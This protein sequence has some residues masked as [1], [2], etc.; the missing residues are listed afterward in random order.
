MKIT[1][2]QI[3]PFLKKPDGQVRAILLYGPDAGLARER[4]DRLARLVVPDAKD[5][6]RIADFSASMLKDHPG[7]LAEEAAQLSLMGGRRV[8]MVREASDRFADAFAAFLEEPVGEA[9]ILVE[10]GDL[11]GRSRL[12]QLFEGG[13][14]AAAIGC[15]PDDRATVASLVEQ[16]L[17][18]RGLAIEGDA[19]DYLADNLGADRGVTRSE[20]EKLAL[21]KGK[22]PGRITLDEAQMMVG[23]SAAESLDAVALAAA[24]GNQAALEIALTRVERAKEEPTTILRAATRHLLRL[25]ALR[26]EVDG[27][28]SPDAAIATAR[29][30]VHFSIKRRIAAQLDRWPS[31]RT[32]MALQRLA[33]AEIDAK[34]TGLPAMTI[35]KRALMALAS[36][37]RSPR[38]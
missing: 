36:Q 28:K 17:A 33:E 35:C 23:D 19:L 21:F 4:L 25:Q 22:G 6:F 3:E 14:N 12:R 30:P 2:R 38:R 31:G 27:G 20:I 29:P 15:Y 18:A 1:G 5:P 13:D 7:R 8:V 37:A 10:A 24:E 26:A 11:A 16:I 9:L 32:G 34:S